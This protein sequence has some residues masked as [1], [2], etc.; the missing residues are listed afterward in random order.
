MGTKGVT[1]FGNQRLSLRSSSVEKKK[2][3]VKTQRMCE[4]LSNRNVVNF[5]IAC[6]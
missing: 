6:F 4:N 1:G 5:F 2:K 3:R